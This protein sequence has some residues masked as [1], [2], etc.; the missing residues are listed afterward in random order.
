MAKHSKGIS[1]YCSSACWVTV[2]SQSLAERVAGMDILQF[3]VMSRIL[4]HVSA[5]SQDVLPKLAAQQYSGQPEEDPSGIIAEMSEVSKEAN[6]GLECV[7][8]SSTLAS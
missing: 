2:R 5:W 7:M 3:K 4:Q 1:S 8:T 6:V